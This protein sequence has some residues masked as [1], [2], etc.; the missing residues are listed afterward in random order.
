MAY[1]L[2]KLMNVSCKHCQVYGKVLWYTK[3]MIVFGQTPKSSSKV[4]FYLVCF[5]YGAL[6]YHVRY[7]SID[8]QDEIFKTYHYKYC[9][10]GNG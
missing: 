4:L 5:I 7:S 10:N 2:S 3:S 6:Y 8:Y 9:S 1:C